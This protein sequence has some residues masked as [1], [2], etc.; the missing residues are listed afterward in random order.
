M[1]STSWRIQRTR[2]RTLTLPNRDRDREH[3]E[4]STSWQIQRTRTLTLPNRDRDR[5]HLGG[6]KQPATFRLSAVGTDVQTVVSPET[7]VRVEIAI[8]L[9]VYNEAGHVLNTI[10]V[11]A[12]A[13]LICSTNNIVGDPSDA[14]PATEEVRVY[15]WVGPHESG[16]HLCRTFV[17]LA[18]PATVAMA[19]RASY[20]V[21]CEVRK[22][23]DSGIELTPEQHVLVA[24]MRTLLRQVRTIIRQTREARK[25][26]Q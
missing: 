21:R 11:P 5:E 19:E 14:F 2:T 23:R 15:M 3:L 26:R 9:V 20:Q 17:K 4:E 24:C 12:G 6:S 18:G 13:T 10:P 25:A 22:L 7:P 1:E 16:G 8:N